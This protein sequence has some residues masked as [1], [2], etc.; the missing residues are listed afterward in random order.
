MSCSTSSMV[1]EQLAELIR[2]R[3]C[4]FAPL[5]SAQLLLR[6]SIFI[7]IIQAPCSLLQ[8]A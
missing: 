8:H 3:E 4:H 7:I 5:P 6:V 1:I 2:Y